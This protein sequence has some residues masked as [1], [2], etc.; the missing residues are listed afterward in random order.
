MHQ[1]VEPGGTSIADSSKVKQDFDCSPTKMHTTPCPF[2][3][4]PTL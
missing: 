2:I 1:V 4:A 3:V